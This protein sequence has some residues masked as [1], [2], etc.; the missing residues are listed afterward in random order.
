M[1]VSIP[2]ECHTKIY[3]F[4]TNANPI[5]WLCFN[6]KRFVEDILY[7]AK[8]CKQTKKSMLMALKYVQGSGEYPDWD[9][10]DKDFDFNILVDTDYISDAVELIK[11]C[12]ALI[13]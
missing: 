7:L 3:V 8:G 1:Y 11:K 5:E 6:N 4:H 13:N 9:N 12:D 10:Y 2:F